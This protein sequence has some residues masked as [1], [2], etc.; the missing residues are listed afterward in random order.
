M[1]TLLWLVPLLPLAGAALNAALGPRMPRAVTTAVGV[2]VPGLTMLLALGI[3][4]QYVGQLAPQPIEQVL[5]AWTAGELS[6]DVAF[7]LDP[8]SAVMLFV[9]TFVGFWIHVYSAGYMSHEPGFQRYFVYLNLF[10]AMMLLLVLGNNFLVLFVGWEGVGLCSYLL[11]GFY[12]TERWTAEAGRKAF[13]VNRI[14][15]FALLVGLFALFATFG[16]LRYADVF[17]AVAADPSLVTGPYALGMSLAAFSIRIT[18][19]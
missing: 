4:W 16:S 8:L 1:L 17:D 12:Y 3:L 9:V 14:G 18:R 5:Y 10:M 7:L 2:G 6:I 11:I 15:D 19:S 13:I